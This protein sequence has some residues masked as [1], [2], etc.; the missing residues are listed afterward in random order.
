MRAEPRWL[1]PS[2]V[3]LSAVG[4][5]LSVYLSVEHLRA[6]GTLACPATATVNCARVTTSEQATLFGVPVALLGVAFFVAMLLVC[7]PVA[8]R[9]PALRTGRLALAGVGVAFVFYLIY[10]EL[11]VV[12][13]I[14]LWCTAV[15]AVAL[16]LFAAVIFGTAARDG[17]ARPAGDGLA[18]PARGRGR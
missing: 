10:A 3:V 4:L 18:R 12:D 14:C 6:P 9:N 17:T 1:A 11:F 8:W 16:A 13:A 2:T 7:A 5:A 15:H